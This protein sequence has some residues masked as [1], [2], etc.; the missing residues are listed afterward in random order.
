MHIIPVSA[1]V[2][3]K[4]ALIKLLAGRQYGA[5]LSTENCNNKVDTRSE[6]KL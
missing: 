1:L 4:G 6:L 2:G 3:Y 5:D